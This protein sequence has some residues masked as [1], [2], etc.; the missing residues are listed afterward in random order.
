MDHLFLRIIHQPSRLIGLLS[1]F[2][3]VKADLIK[4]NIY[5]QNAKKN[6]DLF[7]DHSDQ[8]YKDIFQN[9]ND[10]SSFIYSDHIGIYFLYRLSKSVP[11]FLWLCQSRISLINNQNYLRLKTTVFSRRNK[12]TFHERSLFWNRRQLLERICLD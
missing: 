5:M 7:L 8:L 9:I 1:N 10:D 2:K 4:L 11:I 6:L 3:L 12:I